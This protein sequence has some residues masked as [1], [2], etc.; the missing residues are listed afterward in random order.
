MAYQNDCLIQYEQCITPTICR[1]DVVAFDVYLCCTDYY[2][3]EGL[4]DSL[5]K[6]PFRTS[7]STLTLYNLNH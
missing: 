4:A 1:R 2:E 6:C 5:F 3:T 7:V